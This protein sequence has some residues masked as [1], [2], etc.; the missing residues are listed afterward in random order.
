MSSNKERRAEIIS[1][2]EQI[3]K[4]KPL[5]HEDTALFN[6]LMR[7]SDAM[8]IDGEATS[9]PDEKRSH[10]EFRDYLLGIEQRTALTEPNTGMVV[11]PSFYRT[12]LTGVAQYTELMSRDNVSLIESDKALP[13]RLPEI[14]LSQISSSIVAQGVDAP[15]VANPTIASATLKGF[16]Y[17]VNPLASSFELEQD[18]FESIIDVFTQAF[19]VG[20]ARGIGADLVNGAGAGTAPQGILTAAA[21]SGVISAVSGTW[22]GIDLAAV[23]ASLNR[24]Y[25]ASPKCAWVMHDTTYQQVLALKD[26]NGR[27]LLGIREDQELL[28]GRKVLVSPDMPV[29]AGAKSIVFG[30]LS[31]FYVRVVKNGVMVRRNV[32]APGYAEA[33]ASL[34]TSYLMVDSAVNNA[35]GGVKPI[36][37]ATAHV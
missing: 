19:S 6:S 36:V 5:T 16:S 3:L 34:Y 26:A 12:L 15:P 30:D 37:Y 23:Y 22:S 29:G 27:P 25:R 1:R 11:P 18:S 2:A 32:E 24:A 21:N 31:Q 4:R 14:D 7:L 28:F 13:L 20:L 8:L 10:K 17:R 33:G 9:A 35:G